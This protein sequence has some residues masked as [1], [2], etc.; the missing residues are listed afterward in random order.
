MRAALLTVA[1]GGLI[2]TGCGGGGD[3]AATS[4]VTET[5]VS[6][7]WSEPAPPTAAPAPAAGPPPSA[8]PPPPAAAPM[9]FTMPNLIGSSLQ[10]AQDTM[11]SVTGNP[12]FYSTSTDLTG[13]DRNQMVDA[14][15]QVCTSSPAP[16]E[17]FAQGA[18]VNFGVVRIG[19]ENC[20]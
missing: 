10:A 1:T 8:A 11:Q 20:P 7:Q 4:T 19:V 15:W 6:Y 3:V 16:G 12:L 17:T 13:E 14:N 5:Q 18:P 2:L 9:S